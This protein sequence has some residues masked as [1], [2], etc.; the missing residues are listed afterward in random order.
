MRVFDPAGILNPGNLVP[1]TSTSTPTSTSAPT[2]TST[3]I[4]ID[5][6]SLLV[7]VDGAVDLA[8]LEHSLNEVSLTLAAAIP[9]PSLPV[10]TW[11]ARGAPGA[12]DRWLDPVDHL[13]AG[14]DATL[15][16]G[17]Q[18]S[19]RPAPRRSVGPDLSALLLG[20]GERFGRVDR[21]WLRVHHRGAALPTSPDFD[22]QRDPALARG[23]EILL[24]AIERA[25]TGRPGH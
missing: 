11:L 8:S 9:S 16:D 6:H 10:A 19:I 4:Q 12:R 3:P 13:V 23:E 21:A 25:L 18:I 17:R 20:A 24:E 1:P 14:L 5:H 2:S 7:C 22:H 15:A